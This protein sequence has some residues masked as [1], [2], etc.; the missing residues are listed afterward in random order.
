[1]YAEDSINMLSKAG[2]DFKMHEEKG[3]HVND[4]AELLMTSGLVLCDDV[5][6]ISF[7]SGYDFGY[8]LKLLTCRPLPEDEAAFFESL[9]TY[10]PFIYDLKYVMKSCETL[11]GGLN[12]LASDLNV[13]ARVCLRVSDCAL[14]GVCRSGV[15]A[16]VERI[17]AEHQAG[18]DSLLTGLAFFVL[19]CV[20]LSPALRSQLRAVCV[21]V[22]VCQS[23]CMIA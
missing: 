13:R 20:C 23:V 16:Q 17:G 22:S 7:H 8:L 1:M 9:H 10:F 14:S 11:S 21:C 6:W 15:C 19:R 18:S 2:L 12:K 4:F 5:R 3:I